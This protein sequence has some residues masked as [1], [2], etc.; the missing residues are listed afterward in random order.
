[1][2]LSISYATLSVIPDFERMQNSLILQSSFCIGQGFPSAVRGHSDCEFVTER[3][4]ELS[5]ALTNGKRAEVLRKARHS[6]L[7][8]LKCKQEKLVQENTQAGLRDREIDD[9][10]SVICSSSSTLL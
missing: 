5:M 2:R 7:A 8:G 9:D 3:R 1:M 10:C 4:E 6:D